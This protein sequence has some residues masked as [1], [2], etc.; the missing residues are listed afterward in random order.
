MQDYVQVLEGGTGILK[1]L[2][3]TKSAEN[4]YSLIKT[5]M[6]FKLAVTMGLVEGYSVIDKF[7]FNKVITT[8][9]DPEDVWEG[10]GL[11]AYDT[12]GTAPIVSLASDD[13]ADTMDISIDGLDINGDAVNQIITLTGTTRVALTT[14]LWRVFRMENEGSTSLSGTAFCYTGTGTVPSIGDAEVR[15]LVD[16]GNNQTQM[17]MY[18]VPKGYVGFLH[19]GE[20]GMEFTG[21]ASSGNDFANINY[22]SRRFGKIFKI[23]KTINIMSQGTSFYQETR[24]F[25]DIIPELTDIKFTIKEVSATMG[26]TGAFDILLVE[27][28]KLSAT[29]LAKLGM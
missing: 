12:D 7:G 29:L 22:N 23:K 10:G 5:D 2:M 20:L 27:K 1:K 26:I 6:D 25:P 11:Y 16:D 15:A 24:R 3:A 4:I 17:A 13:A 9:T 19:Y 18:T 28:S 21:G 14:A 8:T